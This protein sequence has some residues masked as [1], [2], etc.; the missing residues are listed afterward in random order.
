VIPISES[1]YYQIRKMWPSA[2]AQIHQTDRRRRSRVGVALVYALPAI[3]FLY[4]LKCILTLQG[5]L[6]VGS[7]IVMRSFHLVTV[8]ETAA[9]LT[10]FGYISV[11]IFAALC[12]G[13]PP[14]ENRHWSLRILRGVARWGGLV[15]MFWFWQR[16][17]QLVGRGTP[18]PDFQ[19]PES[20]LMLRLFGLCL[21]SIALLAFLWAV[22]QR[23]AVKRELFE[24]GCLP[25]HIWWR[26]AAYWA[27]FLPGATGFRV[28][29]RDRTRSLHKG[30]CAVYRSCRDSP[31]WGSRRVRWLQDEVVE[32]PTT[33]SWVVVD[34][35]P[36]RDR[37]KRHSTNSDNL[38]AP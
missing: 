21:G 29:Y 30:Y 26:P 2:A 3:L 28:V 18:W 14:P 34:E 19:S 8:H 22:F 10:G 5:T 12:V 15:G 31:N 9:L 35:V 13:D 11:A 24:N 6:T 23:E 33:E 36:V 20:L 1:V 27:P 17:C 25:V 32:T 16:A 7:R 4:G 38:L 37:L